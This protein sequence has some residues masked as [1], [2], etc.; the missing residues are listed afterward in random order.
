MAS[1]VENRIAFAFP[2]FRIDR[3][4]RVMSTASDNSVSDICR[5][6]N[7]SSRLTVIGM[8]QTVPSNSSRIAEPAA[9]TRLSTNTINTD[10]QPTIEI[11]SLGAAEPM[12]G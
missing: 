11:V 4:A 5:S 1:S 3:F 12:A 8:A 10:I 2:V 9:N 6:P 7:T